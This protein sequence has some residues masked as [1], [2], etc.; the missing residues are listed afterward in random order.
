MEKASPVPTRSMRVMVPDGVAARMKD[1]CPYCGRLVVFVDSIE[2]YKKRSFGM[3][4]VCSHYP[5]CDSYVGCHPGTSKPLGR[6]ADSALRA[7]KK[8]AHTAFDQRWKH[9]SLAD[10]I[11]A[12]EAR[13]A[14]YAWLSKGLEIKQRDCHI[15]MFDV[16]MCAKVVQACN[17]ERME[18]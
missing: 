18:S 6:L 14:A 2:I 12:K 10:G 8:L 11:S 17:S 13:T 1:A 15:G 3:A 16:E 7:A 4:W 5:R 9:K